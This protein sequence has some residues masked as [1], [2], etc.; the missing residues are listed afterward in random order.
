MDSS[1][2][3]R[4]VVALVGIIVVCQYIVWKMV[5]RLIAFVN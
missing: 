2:I 3:F 1:N 5:P 4:D